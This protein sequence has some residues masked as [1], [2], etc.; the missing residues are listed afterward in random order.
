MPLVVFPGSRSLDKQKVFE[1]KGRGRKQDWARLGDFRSWCKCGKVSAN[2]V[3]L[4]SKYWPSE[5]FWIV[6][7]YSPILLS[8]WLPVIPGRVRPWLSAVEANS[9]EASDLRLSAISCFL[10]PGRNS[11]LEEGTGQLISVSTTVHPLSLL[12]LLLH[13]FWQHILWDSD[14]PPFLRE[15]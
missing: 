14:G 3:E 13:M 9:E 6:L 7:K 15:T 11:F 2:P 1:R 12:N 4:Q 5:E 10:Q 8:H